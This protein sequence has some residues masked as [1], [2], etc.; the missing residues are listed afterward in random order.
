MTKLEQATTLDRAG[1]RL[2]RAVQATL[3]PQRVR[4]LLHGVFLGHP[5][6][7]AM[8]QV[9]VIR[10]VTQLRCIEA[11]SPS[12]AFF[13]PPIQPTNFPM[14]AKLQ[15]D[16]ET[17]LDKVKGIGHKADGM[18]M[19]RTLAIRRAAGLRGRTRPRAMALGW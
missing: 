13:A 10:S 1:D 15:T 12:T 7:P 5:L 4:D 17:R 9:P 11:V 8:V 19:L 3:R 6:H 14:A 16:L 2:Q 18:P